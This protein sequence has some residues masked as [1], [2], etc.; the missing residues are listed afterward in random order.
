M[1]KHIVEQELVTHLAPWY[2]GYLK[3]LWVETQRKRVW[4]SSMHGVVLIFW[5]SWNCKKHECG[6]PGPLQYQKP[7]GTDHKQAMLNSLLTLVSSV[8]LALSSICLSE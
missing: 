6:C 1:L 2:F 4:F 8:N 3:V 7:K 5:D